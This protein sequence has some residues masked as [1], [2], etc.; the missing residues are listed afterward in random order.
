MR[1]GVVPWGA[2]ELML[3]GDLCELEVKRLSGL[4]I[5]TSG[6]DGSGKGCGQSVGFGSERLTG[7]R[8]PLLR[9]AGLRRGR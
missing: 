5:K 2:N 9:W 6:L 4:G 7:Q 8:C 1:K 3:M